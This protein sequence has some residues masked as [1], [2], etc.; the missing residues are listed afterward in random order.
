LTPPRESRPAGNGPTHSFSKAKQ[1][2]LRID[3][4]A[5]DNIERRHV[6][7]IVADAWA[8][9]RRRRAQEFLDARHRPGIDFPGRER[10]PEQHRANNVVLTEIAE[11]LTNSAALCPLDEIRA[12]VVNVLREHM[13]VSPLGVDRGVHHQV[14]RGVHHREAS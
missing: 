2:L 1:A 14:D 7:A 12:D 5:L 3:Q 6:Q 8:P 4:A 9:Q 10:T 11:A 13:V